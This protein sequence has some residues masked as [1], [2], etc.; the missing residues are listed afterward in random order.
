MR[1]YPVLYF[2]IICSGYLNASTVPTK[3]VLFIGN[4][5]IYA[6][7]LPARLIEVGNAL[8]SVA[9]F[10]TDQ[11]TPGGSFFSHHAAVGSNARIKIAQEGWDSV[12]LQE[13]S[14][15]WFQFQEPFLSN[16]GIVNTDHTF[17]S[18]P[19]LLRNSV[20]NA[21]ARPVFMATWAERGDPMNTSNQKLVTD[22]YTNIANLYHTYC[23]PCGDALLKI[24]QEKGNDAIYT[25]H[26]H[27]TYTAQ[28]SNAYVIYAT[29]T[30]SSPIGLQ[31]DFDNVYNNTQIQVYAWEAYLAYKE[32][33]SNSN[34][35]FSADTPTLAPVFGP[36]P[37]NVLPPS[38]SPT[39][40]QTPV[41]DPT[42]TT[43]TWWMILSIAV[44]G[45]LFISGIVFTTRKLY[46][47]RA[48]GIS[49]IQP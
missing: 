37:I 4:S 14:G 48:G 30:G 17:I 34:V 16:Y 41:P 43:L 27:P 11:A 19:L 47:K 3:N 33:Q 8:N 39:T 12:I 21:G 36:T 28:V 5:L 9:R 29:L 23:T 46:K 42:T 49:F 26:V 2:C 44:G 25:D 24:Q 18:Y 15:N 13:Q 35:L 1:Y 32:S 20:V 40:I 7:D 22:A 10:T 38:P 6:N 31:V 45:V